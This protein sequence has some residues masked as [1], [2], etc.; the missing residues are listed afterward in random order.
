MIHEVM[1]ALEKS[2]ANIGE[3]DHGQ[4]QAERRRAEAYQV[5]N[6][7]EDEVFQTDLY[8]WY[9]EHGQADK[10]LS[11]QSPFVVNYLKR[12]SETDLTHADLLWRHHIQTEQYHDAAS[13][14]LAL[15]KSHFA[16]PLDRRIEYLSRAKANASTFTAGVGRQSRQVLLREV[17][18][19]LDVANIQDD[20]LQRLREE[21]R[22]T[23]ERKID[24]LGQVDGS[25]LG[26]SEVSSAIFPT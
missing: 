15:A 26:L 6:E 12:K 13:V 2:S 18:D 14:Q 7:S 21:T 8:D 20:L 10:L 17:S 24:V 3:A 22:I 5:V 4:V 1:N 16:L 23:P 19:L 25:I 9:L 11:I